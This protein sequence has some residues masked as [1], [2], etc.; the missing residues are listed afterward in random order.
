MP[1][2]FTANVGRQFVVD[3]SRQFTEKAQTMAAPV[4]ME[5]RHLNSFP[6]SWVPFLRSYTHPLR[7]VSIVLGD[8]TGAEFFS[9]K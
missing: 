9:N 8:A 3:I 6:V 7:D 4:L 5:L 2:Y 1:A